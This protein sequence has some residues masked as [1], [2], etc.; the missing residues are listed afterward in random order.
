LDP[1]IG[2]SNPQCILLANFFNFIIK[3][4]LRFLKYQI[5]KISFKNK[6]KT[7]DPRSHIFDPP[8][9]VKNGREGLSISTTLQIFRVC[10]SVGNGPD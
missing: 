7:K 2:G 9:G 8:I 3:N 1:E 10:L 6:S 5:L 4:G